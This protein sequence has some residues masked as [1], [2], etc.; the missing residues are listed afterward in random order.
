MFAN[1]VVSVPVYGVEALGD[2]RAGFR[3]LLV[4]HQDGLW[5]A[6]LLRG[7]DGGAG[8]GGGMEGHPVPV[9][10]VH[11]QQVVYLAFDVLDLKQEQSSPLNL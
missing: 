10:H 9:L 8:G 6:A 11:L 3:V 1:G 4:V 5:G 2:G 7:V